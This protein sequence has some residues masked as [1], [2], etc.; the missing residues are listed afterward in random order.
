MI[1]SGRTTCYEHKFEN[2][3]TF[4][5]N[6]GNECIQDVKFFN[7]QWSNCPVEIEDEVKKMWRNWGLGN[8]HYFI[9][10]EWDDMVHDWPIITEFL[11]SKGLTEKDTIIIHWWW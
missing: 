9:K 1:Y 11:K 3:K 2:W 6:Y 8:D 5:S 4:P 10:W 7:V